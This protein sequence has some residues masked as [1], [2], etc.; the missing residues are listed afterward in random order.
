M[1]YTTM[2]AAA[3]TV[4]KVANVGLDSV[5]LWVDFSSVPQEWCEFNILTHF[6]ALC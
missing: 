1:H 5:F 6:L 4:A 3:R 2:C